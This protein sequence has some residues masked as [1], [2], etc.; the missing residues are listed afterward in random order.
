MVW[1]HIK[2]TIRRILKE[3]AF[4]GINIFGLAVGFTSFLVLFIYVENEKSFDKHFNNYEKIYRVIST[5]EGSESTTWARS[6]GIINKAASTIPEIE[7]ATQF[8]HCPV[9]TIKINGK[10]FQQKDIMSV[11]E[12]FIKMFSVESKIGNMT[13]ISNPNTA[14]ISEDFAMKYFKDENPIGKSIEIEALQYATDLGLYEIR[15]VVKNTHPKTHFNYHI[16]LSQKGALGERYAALP[17]NK[18][19]WVYNYV[20]LKNDATPKQVSDK[21]TAY[22]NDSNLK[23]IRGPKEYNYTLIPL[24]DIHLKSDHRFELKESSNKINIELFIIISL[25][26]LLVSLLN[27]TNLTIARLIKR[28]KELGLRKSFGANGIQLTSQILYEVLILCM[29]SIAISLLCIEIAKS[30]INQYFEVD[31][32]IYYSE[33]IV[34]LSIIGVLVVCLGITTLFIG[35]FLFRKTNTI[36]ILSERNNFSRNTILKSLLVLQVTVVIILISSTLMVNKQI[37]F[38]SE[39]SLGFNKE[40]IVVIHLKD[41][42][43]DAAIFANELEKQS[44]IASVGFSAQYFG[45]PAQSLPLDGLGIDGTAEFV[46]A[47]YNYLKTMNIQLIE[48]WII[49]SA[50]TISGMVINTHLYKRL[51]EKH[52]SMDALNAFLLTQET[53]PDQVRINFIGVVND[54]NYQS[55]HEE[56]GD[57]AF[58]LGESR[59]RS[60]FIHVLINAG[61]LKN[62]IDRINDIWNIHYPGQ[63]F[64]YFFLDEKIAQQ[65]NAEKI[66]GRILLAFSVLGF[67]I[68]IIGISALSLFISQQR[69]KE[70]GV[71]KV[72]GASV[73]EIITMFNNYFIKWIAIAFVIAVPIS[74]IAMQKWLENFAYKTALSWWIFA[75]AGFIT[76]VI[77]LLT[78]SWQTFSAARKNPVEALRY[79]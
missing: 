8:S 2:F 57:F 20:K 69:T 4:Y 66:L 9:G 55:A 67:L 52:G 53:E 26:V 33:P 1:H 31:F 64:N 38:I 76:I 30:Y 71:R 63:E 78:V 14:F 41:Y 74:Y 58:W 48:N 61:N 13:E 43:K 51:M 79:E 46:F 3:K 6:L 17:N 7:E 15:G 75:L 77:V 65:Y 36:D 72:N 54:F 50:D 42:S 34:Y 23:Q 70:I 11:D 22:H 73:Y 68:S 32:H 40:N 60:R 16:L 62:T 21:L 37:R 25:V 59:N 10:S 56:I 39:K 5:P 27:F 24:K 44:G 18:I 19:Q 45:Y 29:I 47:N 49:P 28:S 35:L 12:S